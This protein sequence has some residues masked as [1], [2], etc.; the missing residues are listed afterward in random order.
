M[1]APSE[2]ARIRL[3]RPVPALVALAALVV[4]TGGA[5]LRAAPVVAQTP[6]A[7]TLQAPAP[8]ATVTSPMDVQG[9]VTISPF[10][11][12]L[13]GRVYDGAG[14]VIGEGPVTVVPDTPGS[15]GGPGAFS[16]RLTFATTTAGPGRI[17][18][19]D[20]SAR[21]GSVLASASANIFFSAGPASPAEP[22]TPP[23]VAGSWLD[24]PL[25]EGGWNVAG[26]PLPAPPR[27]QGNDDPHCA[28]TERPPETP[29]DEQVTGAG[30]RLFREFQGGWDV[31]LLFALS[32]YDGTCRPTGYQAFVFSA[33]TFAGTLAPQSMDA[34][35][36][37]SLQ[38]VSWLPPPPVSAAGSAPRLVA[39]F[40]R[41][42]ADDPL[43]CPSG[44]SQVTFELRPAQAGE[45]GGTVVPISVDSGGP[46][47][48]ATTPAPPVPTPAPATA[49]AVTG[50]LTYRERI[51]LPP[52]AVATVVLIDASRAD[53]PAV[54]I[55]EQTIAPA[56]QVPIPFGLAYDP[57]R[58]DPRL[59]YVVRGTITAGGQLLYT[60]TQAYPVIT[61]GAPV[62]VEV[63]LRRV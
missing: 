56:G 51:A 7:V 3:P 49:T 44:T 42:T 53:A 23:A 22:A 34:R 29:E 11:N 21:D 12:N 26:G 5:T 46:D 62:Q 55:A 63:V 38:S 40:N 43:C 47:P 58:I 32:G 2:R 41:Y 16:A 19:A 1:R 45:P 20:L 6:R 50:T 13:V 30:W 37:S 28:A 31:R 10:E 15:L 54:T 27:R 9:R 48:G 36:D 25:T 61:Q 8:G 17:E 14:Q 52:D 57:A 4:V 59:R 60:S 24:Q 35:T 39:T 33:G 18:V